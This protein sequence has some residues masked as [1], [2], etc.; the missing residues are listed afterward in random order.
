MKMHTLADVLIVLR[1]LDVRAE[2]ISLPRDIYGYIT[3]KAHEIVEA[4]ANEEE[5]EDQELID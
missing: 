4:D 5:A 3:G 1:Q 2:E